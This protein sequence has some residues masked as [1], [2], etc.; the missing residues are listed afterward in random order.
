MAK[1]T[2]ARRC[3]GFFERPEPPVRADGLTVFERRIRILWVEL[4]LDLGNEEIQKT[5]TACVR[6]WQR[7]I[8]LDPEA[9]PVLQA[10]KPKKRLALIS[11]FDH[12]PHVHTLLSEL[13]LT[14]FFEAVVVS[15]DTGVKKPD[16]QIFTPALQQTGLRAGE[17]VYVGDTLEDVQG[18][19]A[20]GLQPI[21]IRRDS[22]SKN[23]VITDFIE[24]PLWKG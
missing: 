1:E 8:T 24:E 10:L 15:G 5:A 9:M 18:A 2:F 3:D 20:A 17:V 6:A 14:P 11:N 21:R 23:Q 7:Y 13:G 4:G 16:P 19:Q 22:P 12:P